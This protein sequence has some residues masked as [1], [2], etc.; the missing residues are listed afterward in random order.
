MAPRYLRNPENLTIEAE[1]F[2]EYQRCAISHKEWRRFRHGR[3]SASKHLD[4]HGMRLQQAQS[5]FVG[6]H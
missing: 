4:L 5:A 1:Q 2:V 6:F 3:F